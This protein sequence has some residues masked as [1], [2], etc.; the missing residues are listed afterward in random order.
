VDQTRCQCGLLS[1]DP[2][3]RQANGANARLLRRGQTCVAAVVAN[4]ALEKFIAPP[5]PRSC[6]SFYGCCALNWLGVRPTCC[7]KKRQKYAT[8]LKPIA[9]ETS[10]TEAFEVSSR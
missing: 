9:V 5:Q 1:T 8:A 7:L 10:D 4:P 3:R 2:A 6:A